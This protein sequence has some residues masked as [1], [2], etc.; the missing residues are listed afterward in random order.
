MLLTYNVL[1]IYYV[2]FMIVFLHYYDVYNVE[3]IALK[4]RISGRS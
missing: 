4:A 3:Y 1:Y 2:I